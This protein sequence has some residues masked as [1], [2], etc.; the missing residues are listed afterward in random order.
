MSKANDG[1]PAFPRPHSDDHCEYQA[2]QEWAQQG[3]SDYH[4]TLK[5]QQ[6]RL[7][8]AMARMNIASAAD[9]HRLTGV[10][11]S[12]IG[13]LLNFKSSPRQK[14]NRQWKI[15]VLRI[16]KALACEPSDIFPEYLDHEI[17]SNKIE[18]FIEHAQ[19]ENGATQQL[20]PVDECE[21]SEQKDVI[22]EVLESLTDR[23]AC[24]LRSHFME[25]MSIIEI[26]Q[27]HGV[28]KQ[29]MCEIR[30]KALRKLRH[31]SRLN[32][33]KEVCEFDC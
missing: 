16:C 14:R 18:A 17:A 8:A 10:T 13:K 1:G 31:P 21:I 19:L 33:L 26:A 6:G 22:N 5:I 9:L 11:Q 20:S 3:M 2:N 12:V 24:V 30:N 32:K 29:R 25:G 4:A 27:Y 23:E 15:S 7:K 28:C